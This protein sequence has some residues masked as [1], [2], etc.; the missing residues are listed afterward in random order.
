MFRYHMKTTWEVSAPLDKVYELMIDSSGWSRWWPDID[1]SA[2]VV[3]NQNDG[4]GS[5]WHFV[6]KTNYFYKI[7][8]D[9]KI[10]EIIEL[11]K[12]VGIASGDL[13]GVGSW[14]FSHNGKTT[15][16]SYDWDVC[17]TKPW[18]TLLAP[19]I[20]RVFEKNHE[21]IMRRGGEGIGHWLGVGPTTV[22]TLNLLNP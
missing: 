19:L 21:V 13:Q 8:F 15:M 5:V 12:I 6:W 3:L 20:H 17:A 22:K 4:V 1:Q 2:L 16:V 7:A 10:V 9:V 11:K 18:M 14:E